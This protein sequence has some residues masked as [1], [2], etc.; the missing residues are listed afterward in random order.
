MGGT[1]IMTLPRGLAHPDGRHDQL[2]NCRYVIHALRKKPMVLLNLVYRD[3]LFPR[4]AYWRAYEALVAQLPEKMACKVTVEIRALAHERGCEHELEDEIEAIMTAG[5]LPDLV[6]LRRQFGPDPQALP[7][8]LVAQV[9]LD[10]YDA[11]VAPNARM[12]ETA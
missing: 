8:V 12:S 5:Q 6:A 11:L 3:K 10:T 1:L 4:L 2:V 9:G 7:I